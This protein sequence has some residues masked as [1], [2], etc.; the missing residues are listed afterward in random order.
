MRKCFCSFFIYCIA[1][2]SF[3]LSALEIGG[4][5]IDDSDQ[6]AQ[7]SFSR[8]AWSTSEAGRTVK[9]PLLTVKFSSGNYNYSVRHDGAGPF[10]NNIGISYPSTYNWYQSG[11]F[12]LLI[13]EKKYATG[14]DSDEKFYVAEEGQRADAVFNWNNE[15]AQVSYN[16]C[17]F[18]HDRN[19]YLIIK[20]NPH[21]EIKSLSFKMDAFPGGFLK[22]HQQHPLIL[23]DNSGEQVIANRTKLKLDADKTDFVFFGRD[24]SLLKE[25][26]KGGCGVVFADRNLQAIEI[27]HFFSSTLI[28]HFAPETKVIRLAFSEILKASAYEDFQKQYP[29]ALEVLKKIE[30]QEAK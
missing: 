28:L 7:V 29:Q 8:G 20:I 3:P 14:I 5:I 24:K 19:L 11:G 17:S 22:N 6:R 16:F 18:Y 23:Y 15:I 27:S 21:Q 30:P 4:I 26:F 13:N 10:K 2:F 1:V 25:G 12:S 9:I